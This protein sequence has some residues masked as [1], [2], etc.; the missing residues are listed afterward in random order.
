M[1]KVPNKVLLACAFCAACVALGGVVRLAAPEME[2]VSQVIAWLGVAG[3]AVETFRWGAREG[4]AIRGRSLGVQI[5]HVLRCV[6]MTA[7]M[8]VVAM[9]AAAPVLQMVFDVFYRK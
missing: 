6:T 3:V 7:I 1:K 4:Y 8:T 5:E 9:I 2:F